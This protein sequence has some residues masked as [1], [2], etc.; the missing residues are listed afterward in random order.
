MQQPFVRLRRTFQLCLWASLGLAVSCA[1]GVG[2]GTP[3]ELQEVTFNLPRESFPSFLQLPWPSDL[4]VRESGGAQL[5]DLRT[6]PNPTQNQTLEEYIQLFQTADGWQTTPTLYFHV[7]GGV[8]DST[9]PQ[10]PQASVADD[11][12]MFLVE[13]DTGERIPLTYKTYAEATA[14]LPAG[15]VA[16]QP[17]WGARLTGTT[18]LVVT[19]RALTP[20][21]ALL[22]ASDDL[23]A[24]M[25][26]ESV[27]NGEDVT[28]DVDC[29]TFEA[30]A[31]AS[32]EDRAD[33]A[34]LQ[35]ITPAVSEAGLQKAARTVRALP[36]PAVR[37]LR[38]RPGGGHDLYDVYEGTVEL[39]Q[40][41]AGEP[42]Y[43]DFNGTEGGFEFTD[44]G[45]VVQRTEDVAFTLAVPHGD[46]PD[47]GWPVV[48]YGHGTGGHLN[49]SLG[50]GVR[51]EAH[52][53]AAAGWATLAVS[54][55]HHAT[56]DGFVDGSEELYTFN[57]LNPVAGRDNWRQSALEKMQLVSAV[58]NMT[59]GVSITGGAPI[60]FNADR[61]AYMG[62]SQGG[63]VGAIVLGVE[64]RFEGAFLSGAGAGFSPSLIAKTEPVNMLNIFRT[65]LALPEDE[66][67]DDY[68]PVLALLQL[69][70]DPAD[71]VNY[72]DAWRAGDG[73][74]TPH[75]VMTSGLEDAFTPKRNHA[76]LAGAFGLPVVEPVAED[77]DVLDIMGVTAVENGVSGN[78][79][80][81]QGAITTGVLQYPFDG[82]FAIY[83][84][85]AG[86]RSYLTFFQSL[87]LGMPIARTR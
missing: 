24:L 68:H 87:L 15:T 84:N 55:P 73:T 78:D 28:I 64:A 60:P 82:H 63:I 79:V 69:W 42:P 53:L 44:D 47:G 39:A 10:S 5:L 49:S 41:Q 58:P 52:Q 11:A 76:A 16:V 74:R 19:S 13:V 14:Y 6:F 85:A 40:F 7:E 36:N 17:L 80:G 27:A 12:S 51:N 48:V 25:R 65:L 57:L 81:A 75:L 33:I 35:I 32:G 37:D 8:D 61:V 71:P 62:H 46:P 54:E 45:A 30:A 83:N 26:C 34:L 4:H 72:G 22:S 67:I 29:G 77:L 3:P 31:A 20:D 66:P 1:T 50:D 18:A 23:A 86:Q 56:R 38:Q 59:L 2:E 43:F 21:G 9:L 70:V